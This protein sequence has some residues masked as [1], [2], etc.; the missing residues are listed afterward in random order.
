MTAG[1]NRKI[2]IISMNNGPDDSYGG[3]FVTGTVTFENVPAALAI[4]RPN[5]QLRAQGL[6]TDLTMDL[7]IPK[8]FNGQSIVLKER[9]EIQVIY[10]VGDDFHGD[11][12]RIQGVQ[13]SKRP[14]SIGYIHCSL[15][16]IE[17]SRSAQ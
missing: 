17:Y 10:P 15:S 6:E 16:R 11:R 12:F 9:D 8:I 14:R 1:L 4:F 5:Q 3:A 13:P 2:N 7:T